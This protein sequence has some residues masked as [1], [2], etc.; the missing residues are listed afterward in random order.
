MITQ[1]NLQIPDWAAIEKHLMAALTEH[2]Y[3]H[4]MGVT[5]TSC[6]LAMR[7]KADVVKARL[8]GL[9]HDCAKCLPAEEEVRL[10]IEK[11]VP[12]TD[13]EL[14]HTALLH[15]K[16]GY[17][18][19][20]EDYGIE[21][22]EVLEAIRWHTT[23]KPAMSLLEKIVYTTDYIEPNRDRAPHL[24]VLRHMA[25][26]DLDLCVTMILKDTVQYLKANEQTSDPMTQTAYEYYSSK[27]HTP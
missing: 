12:V 4:T 10:C 6:A 25:F 16:L 20:K 17:V 14:Q 5:Y 13:F 27:T 26:T 1:E 11:H 19:A 18:L 24:D 22:P 15:A 3:R 23:G 8:A 2:R 7:Y 9:L 21:D